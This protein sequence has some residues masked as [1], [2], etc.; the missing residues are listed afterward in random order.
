MIVYTF[1]GGMTALIWTDVVQLAIYL[2]GA[3]ASAF[4]LWKQIPGGWDEI[5]R[6]AMTGHKLRVFD[7]RAGPD[8]RLHVLVGRHRRRVPHHRH[9]RHR[10][11]HGA[12]LLVQPTASDRP[13]RR[14]SSAACSCWCS[15]RCSS[16][17]ARCSTFSTPPTRQAS[18]RSLTIDG[19]VASDRVFPQFIVSHLPPG[20]MGLVVAAILAAAM[21]SSLN[22][23]AAAA[24]A[25]FYQPLTGRR[26][27]R[28]ALPERIATLHCSLRLATDR[29]RPRRHPRLATNRGRS[30]RHRVVHERRDPR[31]LSARNLH[32]RR[33]PPRRVRWHGGRRRS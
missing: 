14:C 15:L 23:S 30:A 28:A 19:R 16:R 1:L 25:D 27:E 5:S 29:S 31:R 17:S 4:I 9:A 22:A 24:L 32:R 10:P 20:L 33:W 11:V 21:S 18:S 12:A 7:F 2:I 13:A 26:P 6:L 3:L 8:A